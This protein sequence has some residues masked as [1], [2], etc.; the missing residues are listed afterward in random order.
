M[1]DMEE[2]VAADFDCTDLLVLDN[3]ND[4]CLKLLYDVMEYQVV[5]QDN[6]IHHIKIN[7]YNWEDFYDYLNNNFDTEF[8]YIGDHHLF[9]INEFKNILT[10]GTTLDI[11]RYVIVNNDILYENKGREIA[12]RL[13]RDP[14]GIFEDF[15]YYYCQNNILGFLIN[16]AKKDFNKRKA[17]RQK[18]DIILYN[19]I[20]TKSIKVNMPNEV[21]NIITSYLN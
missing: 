21:H 16:D 4:Y 19:K 9:D 5:L 13:D 17:K 1:S 8:S 12:N 18:Y 10:P 11:L 2:L 6:N 3:I 20:F 15:I 7:Y 14:D